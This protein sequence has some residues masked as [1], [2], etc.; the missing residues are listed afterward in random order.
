MWKVMKR[1]LLIAEEEGKE[2]MDVEGDEE[3]SSYCR[4][5]GERVNGCGR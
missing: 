1:G 2:S 5:R 4:R 3:G